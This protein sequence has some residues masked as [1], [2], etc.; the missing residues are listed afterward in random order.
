[1]LSVFYE[2]I[3]GR[4]GVAVV[5]QPSHK[6]PTFRGSGLRISKAWWFWQE[7]GTMLSLHELPANPLIKHANDFN[8]SWW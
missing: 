4:S 5:F 6:L 3:K 7:G 1:M 2:A 8:C